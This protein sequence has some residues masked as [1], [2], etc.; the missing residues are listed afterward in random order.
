[1]KLSIPHQTQEQ[2]EQWQVGSPDL[3]ANATQKLLKRTDAKGI[4]DVV[5]EATKCFLHGKSILDALR[6]GSPEL[7]E[8]II[9]AITIRSRRLGLAGPQGGPAPGSIL[10]TEIDHLLSAI[11]TA[12]PNLSGEV[13]EQIAMGTVSEWIM[14]CPL[15]FET[16]AV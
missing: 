11:K 10:S 6:S 16:N 5:A 8:R 4:H 13:V 3:L 2:M 14:R 1:L 15:D 9:G 12:A 7:H